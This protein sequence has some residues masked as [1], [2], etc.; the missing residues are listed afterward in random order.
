[1]ILQR[2]GE[3]A[4]NQFDGIGFQNLTVREIAMDESNLFERRYDPLKFAT[5]HRVRAEKD[6][7]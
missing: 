1:V 4:V 2:E 6:S 5:D 3:L 7:A